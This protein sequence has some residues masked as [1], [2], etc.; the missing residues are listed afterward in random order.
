M[1]AFQIKLETSAFL[2]VLFLRFNSSLTNMLI[3]GID[4]FR[5]NYVRFSWRDKS[6]NFSLTFSDLKSNGSF[7]GSGNFIKYVPMRGKGNFDFD[8]RSK[9]MFNVMHLMNI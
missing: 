1:L 5:V 8:A 9:K 7:D 4:R 3:D 6:M 2:I